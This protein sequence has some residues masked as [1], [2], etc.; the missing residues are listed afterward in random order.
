MAYIFTV[1]FLILPFLLLG[2]PFVS[3]ATSLAIAVAIIFV[4]NYYISVAKDLDFRRRFLEMAMIS[5]GVAGIS[6]LIGIAVKQF[7]GIEL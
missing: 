5:L 3:L 4:F 2:N 1:V 6:F 7:I